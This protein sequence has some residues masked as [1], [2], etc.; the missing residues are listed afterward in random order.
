LLSA[1][2][3]GPADRLLGLIASTAG[4]HEAARQWF[5]SALGLAR[6]IESPVWVAHTLHDYLAH[7][8]PAD[9]TL[10]LRM[11]V[12]AAALCESHGLK[13]LGGRVERLKI[14]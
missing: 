11:R 14:P 10:A 7:E 1:V 8:P 12:E 9:E 13:A 6:R 2:C 4:D 5:E 3:L